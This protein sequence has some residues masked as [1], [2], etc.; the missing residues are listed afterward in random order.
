MTGAVRA[1]FSG[2]HM[3][4][5]SNDWVSS[6]SLAVHPTEEVVIRGVSAYARVSG[7]KLCVFYQARKNRKAMSGLREAR[8]VSELSH[9]NTI[10]KLVPLKYDSKGVCNPRQ[11]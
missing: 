10:G 9:V 2:K 5:S 11:N 4:L 8:K 7:A 3:T 1:S 6:S